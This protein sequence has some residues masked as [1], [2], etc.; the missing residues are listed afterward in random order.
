MIIFDPHYLK[1]SCILDPLGYFGITE[2]PDDV[3]FGLIVP[4][5]QTLVLQKHG[6]IKPI[7]V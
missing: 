4:F 2:P 6:L 5:Y 1:I 3:V 7:S